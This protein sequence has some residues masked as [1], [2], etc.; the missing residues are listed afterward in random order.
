MFAADFRNDVAQPVVRAGGTAPA[1]AK[2]AFGQIVI[3]ADDDE[4][5]WRGLVIREKLL[6]AFAAQIHIR[7]RFRHDDLLPLVKALRNERA[8]LFVFE[9]EREFYRGVL[10]GDETE[11]VIG[12][13]VFFVRISQTDDDFHTE[14][15]KPLI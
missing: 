6:H 15:R 8:A 3:V 11:I 1:D 2:A 13:F 12:L 9:G 10:R 5:A 7:L 14:M 4:I